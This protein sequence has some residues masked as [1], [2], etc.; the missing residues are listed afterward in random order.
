MT[1]CSSK[2]V[3]IRVFYKQKWM[4]DAS[5]PKMLEFITTNIDINDHSDSSAESRRQS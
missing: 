1:A 4:T 5:W 3:C 2:C